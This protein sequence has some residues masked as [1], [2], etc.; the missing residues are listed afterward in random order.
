MYNFFVVPPFSITVCMTAS[1]FFSD[2]MNNKGAFINLKGN[3]MT[4]KYTTYEAVVS[5]FSFL[6]RCFFSFLFADS[7]QTLRH[8][9]EQRL[10]I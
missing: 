1:V 6:I 5:A 2:T 9:Q 10:S 8:S 4:P 3:D 7:T